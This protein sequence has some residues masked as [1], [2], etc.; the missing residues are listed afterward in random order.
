MLLPICSHPQSNPQPHPPQP[1]RPTTTIRTP[2]A[3]EPARTQSA[4][5]HTHTHGTLNA[6]MPAGRRARRWPPPPPPPPPPRPQSAAKATSAGGPRACG[7]PRAGRGRRASGGV[8][9]NLDNITVTKTVNNGRQGELTQGPRKSQRVRARL[10]T[11]NI[12]IYIIYIICAH[13]LGD[14]GN[15]V[16]R[17]EGGL[18]VEL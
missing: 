6:R 14:G 11:F 4:R 16:E 13:R 9:R 1:H 10:C 2:S 15:S 5:A 3:S 8:G 18:V 17:Q 7:S 12:Y